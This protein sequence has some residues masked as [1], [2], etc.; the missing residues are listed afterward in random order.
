MDLL[1]ILTL[2]NTS[3]IHPF[4]VRSL[5]FL[6]LGAILFNFFMR[7]RSNSPT[8]AWT[9]K[10]FSRFFFI[11]AG[12]IIIFFG[13]FL[14][15]KLHF[16][17]IVAVATTVPL[18][19]SL[20]W[21]VPNG[22][23]FVR[24]FEL[25]LALCFMELLISAILTADLF[26]TLSL[27]GFT[28]LAAVSLSCGFLKQAFN[29]HRTTSQH[30]SYRYIS[31]IVS[32][33]FLVLLSAILLF[34]ILPRSH[35]GQGGQDFR[36]IGYTEQ[37]SLDEDSRLLGADTGKVVV[38][39]R[40]TDPSTS[41]KEIATKVPNGLFR[42]KV[43]ETF[44]GKSWAPSFTRG[45]VSAE[46]SAPSLPSLL[47]IEREA[48]NSDVLPAPYGSIQINPIHLTS[49]S[50]RALQ[51]NRKP[52]QLKNGEWFYPE[53]RG[54]KVTYE[55]TL[56]LSK[57]SSYGSGSGDL[58]RDFELTIPEDLTELNTF[59]LDIFGAKK[60]FGSR[61]TKKDTDQ[62]IRD[63]VHFYSS[64]NYASSA[65]T[66]DKPTPPLK[67]PLMNFLTVRHEGNCELFAS[68]SAVLLRKAGIPT[69]L[70]SGFR[71]TRSTRK[72]TLS[73]RTS[74]AHAW[75]EYWIEG[76]GWKVYDPTPR[77]ERI[78]S[79]FDQFRDQLQDSYDQM[80]R[81]WYQYVYSYNTE[82]QIEATQSTV[83]KFKSIQN[84][85]PFTAFNQKLGFLFLPVA[86][87]TLLLVFR[88]S[89][90]LRFFFRRNEG[91]WLVR[92]NRK[93]MERLLIRKMKSK[94]VSENIPFQVLRQEHLLAQ[95]FGDAI[96]KSYLRWKTHYLEIRFGGTRFS[97]HRILNVDFTEF[98]KL[99]G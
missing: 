62:K 44:D 15:L 34:P 32:V 95:V 93:K 65:N 39:A 87:L 99:I 2:I 96:T 14:W 79:F 68:A 26:L 38:R 43:F 13:L 82:S 83:Q 69:R 90:L 31:H 77:T 67:S 22:S 89:S 16:I 42:A 60:T 52:T 98:K 41:N 86:L 59:A 17:L 21:Y 72:D 35:F 24:P 4:T 10:V 57:E 40:W 29:E 9:K 97:D 18:L 73:L 66:Q 78:F 80:E 63:L 64:R 11:I 23:T 84:W 48:L 6:T 3:E 37:I 7:T 47:V 88:I 54:N 81:F 1:A 94:K 50:G 58:P 19:H 55:V 85:N 61:L 27:F 53:G 92:I 49:S 74:D 20:L 45:K 25:R 36:Q 46:F 5:P 12:L 71:I 51:M 70:V 8:K 33:A 56:H 91:P 76:E 28:L 30:L 75:I